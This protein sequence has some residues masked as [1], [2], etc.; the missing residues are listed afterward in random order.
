M[1][2]PGAAVLATCE[3]GSVKRSVVEAKDAL[4]L[5]RVGVSLARSD[6]VAKRSTPGVPACSRGALG[7]F[8]GVAEEGASAFLYNEPW[9]TKRCGVERLQGSTPLVA[10][11]LAGRFVGDLW[12]PRGGS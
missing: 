4:G 9:P 12:G 5:A 3:P 1:P 11:G 2:T 8:F 6:G 7:V 10:A